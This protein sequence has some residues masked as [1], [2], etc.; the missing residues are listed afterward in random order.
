MTIQT[1]SPTAF[2]AGTILLQTPPPGVPL[3][4]PAERTT[5]AA[6][7]DELGARGAAMLVEALR[8]GLHVGPVA[9]PPSHHLPPHPP[10]AHPPS[11]VVVAL[12]HA[13][14]I[15]SADRQVRWA[16]AAGAEDV[17]LRARVLGPLWA[18]LVMP[19]R[20]SRA[21]GGDGEV[22]EK[23]VILEDLSVVYEMGGDGQVGNEGGVVTWVLHESTKGKDAEGQRKEI[24]AEYRVDGHGVVVRMHDGSWL[25]IGKIKVEGSTSKPARQVLESITL[26][27]AD[28]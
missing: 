26:G 16:D 28:T 24:K 5:V 18:H 11:S 17:A 13:P 3:P 2:D 20:R 22:V 1:L 8:R 23:R 4:L 12:R 9:N 10:P 27:R 15:T 7:R 6:L 25:R 14:K 21:G 19:R